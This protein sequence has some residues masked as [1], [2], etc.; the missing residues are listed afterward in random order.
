MLNCESCSYMKNLQTNNQ[1][2]NVRIC[3]FTGFVFQEKLDEYEMENHPCFDYDYKSYELEQKK[4]T[5]QKV[6]IA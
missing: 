2:K 6:K 4:Q 3:E 5:Y 1:D